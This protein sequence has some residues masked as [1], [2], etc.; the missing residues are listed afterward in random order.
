MT[1]SRFGSLDN[2]PAERLGDQRELAFL[3]RELA[4]LRRDIPL[5]ESVDALEWHGVGPEFQALAAR[6]DAA[7]TEKS[8]PKPRQRF[9]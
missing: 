3:F 2:I 4:R 9:A 1:L 6:F 7:R 8:K 5:F